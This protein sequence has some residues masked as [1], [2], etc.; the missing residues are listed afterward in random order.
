MKRIWVA[1]AVL[2]VGCVGNAPLCSKDS[3]CND[4]GACR[5]G[6]CFKQNGGGGQSIS[7]SPKCG[8]YESC[9][10]LAGGGGRCEA[11]TLNFVSPAADSEFDVGSAMS[12]E[13]EARLLDGGLASGLVIPLISDFGTEAGVPASQATAISIPLDT[14][15]GAHT[16]SAGWDAGSWVSQTVYLRSCAKACAASS[17]ATAFQY[18]KQTAEKM[19]SK[20]RKNTAKKSTFS[21]AIWSCPACRL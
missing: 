2:G 15:A 12:V 20:L 3:D 9:E 11:V 13:V 16:L 7:C 14:R 10:A 19:P 17:N 4:N 1:A 21:S 18:S 5:D 6:I 8:A